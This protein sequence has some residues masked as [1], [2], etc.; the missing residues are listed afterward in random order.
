MQVLFMLI[1]PFRSHEIDVE[2]LLDEETNEGHGD[3]VVE[4][5]LGLVVDI[6][7]GG[8]D[9]VEKAEGPFVD[10]AI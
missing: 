6:E 4:P 1:H 8:M 2:V 9:L 7:H 3:L 10:I 5:L